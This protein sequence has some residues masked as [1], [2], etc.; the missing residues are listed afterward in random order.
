[1]KKTFLVLFF[2]VSAGELASQF[3]TDGSTLHHVSKPLIMVTLAIVY[4]VS[5]TRENRSLSLLL[6]M[7]FSFL[8]D[9]FLM[10][11]DKN[12]MYFVLGLGAF[13]VSHIFY[14][15]TYRQHQR[16]ATGDELQ[17]IQK[18][19]LSFPI[20]LAGSGLVVILY[21]TLGDLKVPVVVY[22]LVLV[23]MVLHALFRYGRTSATS[24]WMVFAGALLF[25]ISDSLIAINK[26][27]APVAYEG[28]WIM[29][30][31]ITAQYLIVTGLINHDRK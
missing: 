6:A 7:V 5:V 30:T 20:I 4:G 3:M 21:P 12:G 9:S 31:Y 24:F 14:I 8:G 10:Y 23:L 2:L 28:L 17:G 29:T 26:F 19:K 15:F 13:L 11:Q 27:F 1:M 25:M 18:M 16:E 22:A